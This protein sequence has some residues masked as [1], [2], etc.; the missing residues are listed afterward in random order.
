VTKFD[1]VRVGDLVTATV[2]E[3]VVISLDDK[4]SPSSE[5]AAALVARVPKGAQP[6]GVAAE[7]IRATAK[8]IGIDLEKHTVTLDFNDGTTQTF[9]AR[10]NV[11]LRQHKTGEQ[12]VFRV[13]E[14]VAIW[15]E[16]P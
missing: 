13:T 2:T 11:D 16:K 8:V 14:M 6:G 5:G 12:L 15:V 4:E 7:T 9:L 10:P 3:K 1:L